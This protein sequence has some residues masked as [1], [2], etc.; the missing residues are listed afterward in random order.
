MF[1]YTRKSILTSTTPTTHLLDLYSNV[2]RPN[3]SI[4]LAGTKLKSTY[5]SLEL[6]TATVI[7]HTPIKFYNVI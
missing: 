1:T 4:L 2:F 7:H 3:N 6:T 5:K